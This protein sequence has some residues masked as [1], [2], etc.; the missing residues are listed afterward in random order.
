MRASLSFRTVSQRVFSCALLAI[1]AGASALAGSGFGGADSLPPSFG[2]AVGDSLQSGGG[3]GSGDPWP[4]GQVGL[5]IRE[6]YVIF[7]TPGAV[8]ASST[9]VLPRTTLL[10]W[11]ADDGDGEIFAAAIRIGTEP[12]LLRLTVNPFEDAMPLLVDAGRSRVRVVFERTAPDGTKSLTSILLTLG[13]T[14]SFGSEETLAPLAPNVTAWT[15][16]ESTDGPIVAAAIDTDAGIDI[17]VAHPGEGF[18]ES[19]ALLP[20]GSDPALA[21]ASNA[22]GLLALTWTESD[23]TTGRWTRDAVGRWS[24][25]GAGARFERR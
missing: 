2:A 6:H 10:A 18:S 21:F 9:L 23:G 14:I 15:V 7:G 3:S 17:R 13:P 22:R 24:Q 16:A 8:L 12:A 25:G 5:P 19:L 20:P 4:D 11:R 1:L